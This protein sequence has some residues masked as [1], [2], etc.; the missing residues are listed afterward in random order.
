MLALFIYQGWAIAIKLKL[1]EMKLN[2]FGDFVQLQTRADYDYSINL[3]KFLAFQQLSL[4][5]SLSL[6]LFVSLVFL[7]KCISTYHQSKE[8]RK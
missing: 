6:S 5:L 8:K 1:L 7:F 2:A 4:S 3:I